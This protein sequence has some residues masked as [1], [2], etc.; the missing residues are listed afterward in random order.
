MPKNP[1]T[2]PPLARAGRGLRAAIRLIGLALLVASVVRELRLPQAQRSWHG[3]L[4]GR[5]PYDLR[6][7]RLSRVKA[8]LWNPADPHVLVP[9]SFGVGW[10]VN[11]AAVR[12]R[13]RGITE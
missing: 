4:F 7:P 9:N 5:V 12:A 1:S 6:P 3:L 8:A 2:V 11:L 13:L 10:T